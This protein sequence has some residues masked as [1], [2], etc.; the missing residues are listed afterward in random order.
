MLKNETC[1]S[2]VFHISNSLRKSEGQF[3][4][5]NNNYVTSQEL[6]LQHNGSQT[7]AGCQKCSFYSKHTV[8]EIKKIQQS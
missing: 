1:P 7:L 3:T 2:Q 6:G 8:F 4:K 5:N